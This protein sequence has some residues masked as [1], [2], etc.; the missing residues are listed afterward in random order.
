MPSHMTAQKLATKRNALAEMLIDYI[1]QC[2]AEEMLENGSITDI[3]Y[4][5]Q[6]KAFIRDD[7]SDVYDHYIELPLSSRLDKSERVLQIWGQT[8]CYK[9]NATG[10][11]ESNKTYEIRETLSEAL[12]MRKWLLEED[13]FFRTIHFT[14][15]PSNYTYGWF[16]YAK[17]NAFDLSLYPSLDSDIDIFDYIL[18]ISKDAVYEY[19]FY[20]KLDSIRKDENHPLSKYI[21]STI[22]A[23][24][25][26]FDS[27][28]KKSEHADKQAQ[29]LH[30]IRKQ[31]SS[32]IEAYV[33][34]SKKSGMDIKG[35]AVKLLNGEDILDPVLNETLKRLLSTN[36]F[37]S[38]ALDAIQDWD[39]WSK[40]AFHVPTGTHELPDY[41][42]HLWSKTTED[43]LVIRRL[44]FRAYTDS[45]INYIQD[46]NIEGI[47]EHN[48]YNGDHSKMQTKQ[49]S[50]FLSSRYVQNNIDTPQL[51]YSRLTRHESRGLI[52]DSLKFEQINGASLKPSFFYLEEY[53]K[54]NFSLVSFEEA[55]LPSPIGY[56][57]EFNKTLNVM[58]YNNLKVIRN[59]STNRNLAIVKAKFFRKPEFPRRVKEE[60]Y[61]GL[62]A[63]Y[64]IVDNNYVE[65]YPGLPFIMF[66]DMAANYD[67]PEFAIRRLVNYGW[68]PFFKLD[69]LEDYLVSLE[70]NNE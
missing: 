23:L 47:D 69:A 13:V 31:H 60:S 50:E 2:F 34:S 7:C 51:L 43:R 40:Q 5:E 4:P 24:I 58:P 54:P 37:L 12:T 3:R 15:G 38:V 59:K 63:K 33:N 46:L 64:M 10:K 26:Y 49:V 41:I 25:E 42:S 6:Q 68:Q 35:K 16:Q 19:D 36:P 39:T 56:H 70:N 17:E 45:G 9:G 14:L 65:R 27:G 55:G 29:L 11:P 28:F 57:S 20:E 30:Q 53:L 61:V 66:V 52:N 21:Q 67:P 8:T 18:D 1:L 22:D 32:D 48:L 44:L 62:T